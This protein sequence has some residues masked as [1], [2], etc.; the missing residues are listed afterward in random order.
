MGRN[1]PEGRALR[2]ELE[3]VA[4]ALVLLSR[5]V[6]VFRQVENL[7]EEF[8]ADLRLEAVFGGLVQRHLVVGIADVLGHD[9]DLE[10]LDSA[11][12]DVEVGFDLPLLSE[13]FLRRLQDGLLERLLQRRP[14]DALV[15][16]N[17]IDDVVEVG[18]HW[19]C[20]VLRA[21]RLRLAGA[22]VSGLPARRGE[23]DLEVGATNRL[24]R[25]YVR[26]I[27]ATH[28]NASVA[29]RQQL[30]GELA[31]AVEGFGKLHDGGLTRVTREVANRHQRTF[32]AR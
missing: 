6:G 3:D 13:R 12:I 5:L 29:H 11:F 2:S 1:A 23:V 21:R 24:E 9:D 26:H 25:Q 20:L 18:F 4:V 28:L 7:K 27:T 19:R 16:R 31:A 14:I 30:A 17:L 8:V 32:D 22:A 10:E 15:L